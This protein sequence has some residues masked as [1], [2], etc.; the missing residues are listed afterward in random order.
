MP[1]ATISDVAQQAGL[2]V[3]TVNRAL[4]E[5]GKVRGETLR[6]ILQS[7]ETVG[8]YGIGSI[9]DSMRIT[10]PK[11]R[12][13]I[14]LLQSNRVLY[15]TLNQ[16]LERA[17]KSVKDHDVM[18]RIEHQE[19]LSPQN[20]AE[21]M[22]RL[23]QS[24]D[25]LGVVSTEHPMVA[26]T[27]EN[28][29]ENGTKCFAIISQLTARCNVGYIGIDHWKVGRTAGWAFNNLCK[30]PGKIG[31]LVGSH[32]YRNQETNESGFRS[33]IR[34]HATGFELLEA[35]STFETTSIARELTESLLERHP[36]LI[37]LYVS[38]GG[39][40]GAC[41]ALRESGR[42]KDIVTVGYDL[43]NVTRAGLLDGTIN[44]IIAHPLENLAQE[45]IAAMIRCF[46]GGPDFPPESISLPFDI[47][48]PENL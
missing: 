12:I 10:R 40:T 7:A 19:D 23:A 27:L 3:S 29:A 43:T 42:A 34:E 14:Q 26:H 36:D 13:G 31:I 44:F 18:I 45:A 6:D 21:T 4:H 25:I 35:Q 16:F 48:T 2:S 15:R 38:G 22:T 46:D 20:V 39:I 33:Y 5:P 9:R 41:E 8:F 30:A 11:V 47:Y 37:G 32:R 24:S 28:L 1:R 17:A